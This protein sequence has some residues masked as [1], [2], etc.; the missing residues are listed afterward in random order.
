MKTILLV[1]FPLLISVNANALAAP[2]F[3]CEVDVNLKKVFETSFAL[4]SVPDSKLFLKSDEFEMTL[5]R[6]GANDF[7]LE[8]F[9][10]VKPSRTYITGVVRQLGD[11]ITFAL[12]ERAAMLDVKCKLTQVL[13]R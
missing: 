1:I 3:T 8:T 7:T 12:W 9:D 2:V 10:R 13:R 5:K 4:S 6:T 11:Q